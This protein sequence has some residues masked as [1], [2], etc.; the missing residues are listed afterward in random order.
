MLL[1]SKG[2]HIHDLGKLL[3]DEV[4]QGAGVGLGICGALF[5]FDDED[6]AIDPTAG[7]SISYFVTWWHL[8]PAVLTQFSGENLGVSDA[9]YVKDH[10]SFSAKKQRKATLTQL[11]CRIMLV[12]EYF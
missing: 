1:L 10:P 3:L 12:L 9:C 2:Q 5:I 7:I 8:V 6:D 4:A 11:C